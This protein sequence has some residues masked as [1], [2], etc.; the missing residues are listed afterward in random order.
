MHS[1]KAHISQNIKSVRSDVSLFN[2]WGH[3]GSWLL[4]VRSD[5]MDAFAQ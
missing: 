2:Q 3:N 1:A 4:D 5:W